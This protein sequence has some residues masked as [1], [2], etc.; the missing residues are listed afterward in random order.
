MGEMNSNTVLQQLHLTNS[1]FDVF[2]ISRKTRDMFQKIFWYIIEHNTN[3]F[4]SIVS[5]KTDKCYFFDIHQIKK[6]EYE[7]RRKK[8]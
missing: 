6:W 2:C 5:R 1:V 7:L 3:I 8:I 4:T